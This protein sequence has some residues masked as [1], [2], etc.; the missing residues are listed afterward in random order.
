MW[1]LLCKGGKNCT[2]SAKANGV[3]EKVEICW[4]NVVEEGQATQSIGRE[5]LDELCNHAIPKWIWARQADEVRKA[6]IQ[7]QKDRRARELDGKADEVRKANNQQHKDRRA[8][9]RAQR[10]EENNKKQEEIGRDCFEVAQRQ[11]ATFAQR[12]ANQVAPAVVTEEEPPQGEESAEEQAARNPQYDPDALLQLCND[13][14]GHSITWNAEHPPDIAADESKWDEWREEVISDIRKYVLCNPE[15][16]TEVYNE[17]TEALSP[18]RLI[19]ACG[20]CGVRHFG[21]FSEWCVSNLSRAVFGFDEDAHAQREAL[22]WVEL[23][24]L[25]DGDPHASVQT[26]NK[27]LGE[28]EA[29]ELKVATRRVDLRQVVSSY[30]YGET[31][32]HLHAPLIKEPSD[33][34]AASVMLCSSCNGAALNPMIV[35]KDGEQ[36]LNKRSCLSP[37]AST[38]AMLTCWGCQRP[39]RSSACCC[40]TCGCMQR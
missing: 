9:E 19:H 31:R 13:A 33:G 4:R 17:A 8:R 12:H 23:V 3:A 14:N 28:G 37:T 22:G 29:F 7:Q 24:E 5:A 1:A 30:L 34:S 6:K 39:R 27:T 38:L 36:V 21:T 2:K 11:A 40:L 10:H 18:T 25:A 26:M 16:Q 15:R 20:S 32:Y 35:T